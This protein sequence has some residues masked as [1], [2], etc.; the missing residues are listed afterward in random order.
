MNI[1]NTKNSFFINLNNKAF[2]PNDLFNIKK[3]QTLQINIPNN[4]ILEKPIYLINHKPNNLNM[5]I[6]LG[7]NSKITIIDHKNSLHNITNINCHN[8]SEMNYYLIQDHNEAKITVEQTTNSTFTANILANSINNNKLQLA[9]NLL[10][11]YAKSY[12]NILQNTKKSAIHHINLL[13]NH[14]TLSN[15]SYTF[16]RS[17]AA[18]QSIANII[19]R[20]LVNKNAKN[21]YAN[22]QSKGLLLS[23]QATINSCPELDIYNHDVICTHGSTVGHLDQ[24][25]LFYMQSR[26]INI[27]DA[28]Q[29]LLHAF[30]E[31]IIKNI[32]YPEIINYLAI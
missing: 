21:T 23:K 29:L 16:S 1:F 26:G 10:E 2:K 27:D 25:A 17:I 31:P 4:T 7:E 6:T 18:D 5:I 13:I 28:K 14:L 15:S 24:N 22:L 19:G 32:R 11:Q 20:I 3:S 9:I 8:N 12:I 30:V